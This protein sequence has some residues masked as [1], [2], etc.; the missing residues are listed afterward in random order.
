[1]GLMLAN[2]WMPS[3]EDLVRLGPLFSLV[4]TIVAV[5]VAALIVGRNWRVTAG[6]AVIGGT[7]TA[8][9]AVR[10]WTTLTG[11]WAGMVPPP[12][13]SSSFAPML[14]ADQ[15]AYCF[16]FLL[17]IFIVLIT[18][19]W[20]YGRE[21]GS[22]ERP[23]H[24]RDAVEFFVLLLGSAFGM[25]LMVSTTN[26][27]MI[28]LAVETAS[29]PSYSLA[30]FRK[31]HRLAA[32]ASL[33]YVLFGAVTSAIMIYGAS[34]LYGRFHTLDLG[35]IGRAIA[36]QRVF[37]GS[38]LLFGV[39]LVAF[40]VGAAFKIS[41][42]PFHFWCPDVFEGASIEIT[43][44]LSVVSKGAGLAL[45][46]RVLILMTAPLSYPSDVL[47][48][49]GRAALGSG[50]PIVHAEDALQYVTIAL[51]VMAAIT[52]TVG[53]FAAYHQTNL[54]RLLAFSSIA[55]AGY[56]LM[57]AAVVSYPR[58]IGITAEHP[59]FSAFL[60]YLAVYLVMNFGAFGCVAMVYW[61]TG[62]ETIDAFH[63]LIRR[64][65]LLAVAMVIFLFSL[66]GMPPFAGF[67]A[68]LYLLA[69]LY[70]CDTIGKLLLI[71]AVANT[72]FSLYFY[73]RVA[74]AMCFVDDGQ[75]V[76]RSPLLGRWAVGLCALGI[77]LFGT[78]WAGKLKV[79]TDD[80]S[81]GLNSVGR[82]TRPENGKV[83]AIEAAEIAPR[84]G[85]PPLR[86]PEP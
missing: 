76:L 28:I 64:S 70:E 2:M 23:A 16:I 37:A 50:A 58:T 61:A 14:I 49:A 31:K 27:L 44:W 66:V 52:C 32:E 79:F 25:A 35:E 21:P 9:L 38:N 77:L 78:V 39:A 63:G 41:A 5:L 86:P 24:G 56:M 12:A 8:I 33:K 3:V 20:L 1:M 15:G 48:H 7:S 34:L 26:L 10:S 75:P 51:A 36:A 55:H 80:R 73:A 19:M 69:A 22:A 84:A 57:A 17:G 59:G 42:V 60:F 46:L 11:S 29:L 85:V 40:L 30:G 83:R 71:V 53:N 54:K 13:S 67:M 81:R 4:G 47:G 18:G 62:K 74:Y 65:P 43:T 45:L 68:K 6:L 82:P 72:L